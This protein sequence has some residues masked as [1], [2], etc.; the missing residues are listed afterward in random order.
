M[1]A[2]VYLWKNATVRRISL[3]LSLS[4]FLLLSFPCFLYFGLLSTFSPHYVP[5]VGISFL[6]ISINS[7]RIFLPYQLPFPMEFCYLPFCVCFI[8]PCA[9]HRPSPFLLK[10]LNISVTFCASAAE[11]SLN[12]FPLH[13]LYLSVLVFLSPLLVLLVSHSPPSVHNPPFVSCISYLY[14][15]HNGTCECD[16][17]CCSYLMYDTDISRSLFFWEMKSGREWMVCTR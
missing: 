4:L 1:D 14:L 13:L 9:K 3:S 2:R 17:I 15:I 11:S 6:E 8:H 7:R 12:Y 5:A 10:D 16:L